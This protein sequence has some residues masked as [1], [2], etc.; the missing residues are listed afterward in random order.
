MM[1]ERESKNAPIEPQ[2]IVTASIQPLIIHLSD[3]R[4]R[5]LSSLSTLWLF[6]C[7]RNEDTPIHRRSTA[8]RQSS[9][10]CVG[11][12]SFFVFSLGLNRQVRV[13]PG[14]SFDHWS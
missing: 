13:I 1:V 4:E 12:Q 6:E 5:W 14:L 2:I 11:R 8:P 9:R 7:P 10:R 3:A